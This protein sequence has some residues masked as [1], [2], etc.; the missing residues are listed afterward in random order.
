MAG[1]PRGNLSEQCHL[2]ED[3]LIVVVLGGSAI[4]QLPIVMVVSSSSCWRHRVLRDRTP[5]SDVDPATEW[6]TRHLRIG[7]VV[8]PDARADGARGP[9]ENLRSPS[10]GWAGPLD[11]LELS[12]SAPALSGRDLTLTCFTCEPGH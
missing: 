5:V 8:L 11:G 9:G 1:L 7:F 12:A 6:T 10:C 4:W 3:I 2:E